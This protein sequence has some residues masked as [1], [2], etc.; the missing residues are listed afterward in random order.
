MWLAILGNTPELSALELGS[1]WPGGQVAPLSESIDM[2][3]LGGTVKVA[4][5][6]GPAERNLVGLDK[7]YRALEQQPSTNKL[8]FGFSIYA[9]DSSITNDVIKQ[10][11]KKMHG[12][13]LDWKKKLKATGRSLRYV[14]SLEPT[15][16]SVI[17]RKEHLLEPQTDFV[18]VLYKTKIEL[19]RT[20]QVQDFRTFSDLDYGRPERDHQSGML[21]PKVARMMVNIAGKGLE[22]S[23]DQ[24]TLLDPFCGSGTVL[25]EALTLGYT[26]LIGSDLSAK[27]ID[28]TK[29]NIA[30]LQE[31]VPELQ[32]IPAPKLYQSD[33]LQLSNHLPTH[34]INCVVGEGYLGPTHPKNIPEIH[35][36]LSTFYQTV[37]AA[38]PKLLAPNA[39]VVLALPS[40]KRQDGLTTMSLDT[41]ITRS[42]FT[43]WHKP[44][45]Y[46]REHAQVVRQIYFLNYSN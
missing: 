36:K 29:K 30:W 2:S 4:K 6:I 46:G 14:T 13:G 34:S 17:V 18:L 33:I 40:W 45:S 39:R 37:I 11:S 35:L 8:C 21:P 22:N 31:Q 24:T 1:H 38:L 25:Q 7:L 27:A 15:L 42:G 26:H 32:T 20:E 10:L 28:D 44:I 19:A 16:S 12:I 5:I 23:L 3:K 9:G 41:T 43:Q